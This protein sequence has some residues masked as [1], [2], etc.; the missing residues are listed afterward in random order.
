MLNEN[1]KYITDIKT[2]K[3]F[4]EFFGINPILNNNLI[5][6]HEFEFKNGEEFTYYDAEGN[7]IDEFE[8]RKDKRNGKEVYKEQSEIFQYFIVSPYDATTIER[9]TDDII[10]YSNELDLYLW[11]IEHYG[12]PWDMVP[13]ELRNI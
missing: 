13:I 11:G 12:A 6:Y 7:I 2:Y 8:Y 1:V 4:T 9:Y 3:D 5:N 10:L